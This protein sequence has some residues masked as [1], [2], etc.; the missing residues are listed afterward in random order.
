MKDDSMISMKFLPLLECIAFC[1]FPFT[2]VAQVK[3]KIAMVTHGQLGDPF[4][5]VVRNAA[6][7]A[8]RETNCDLDYRSPDHF[9]LAAMSHLIDEAVASKPDGLIVSIPDVAILRPSIRAAVAAGIPVISI[10]SGLDVSKQLG[11]LMHIGQE[12]ELAGKKAGERMKATGVK[13]ALILNQEVGNSGLDQRIRGFKDGFEGPFHHTQVLP[14]TID[15]E[16]CQRAVNDYLS[17]NSTVDGIVALGPVAAEPSLQA[18][19]ELNKDR[20]VKVCTFDTSPEILNALV[21]YQLEFAVDQQQWLQGY[22]PVVFLA[23][24]VKYG[25]MIQNDLILTGPSFVT[26]ANARKALNILSSES[27]WNP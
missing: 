26:P 13:N 22:L 19:K 9:D 5:L 11:C 12:D 7:T 1:L 18:L 15:F 8:A 25:S 3:P 20:D 10:N 27:G 21:N 6:E 23:N 17:K 2:I 24:Y 16:K 4:W 14:V